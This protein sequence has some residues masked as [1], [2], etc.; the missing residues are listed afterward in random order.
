[1]AVDREQR[2]R[3]EEAR[4]RALIARTGGDPDTAEVEAL[5][6]ATVAVTADG[7]GWATLTGDDGR[8]LG[9]VLLWA[10]RRDV[11][12]LTV[13]VADGGAG[14]VARRAQGLAPVPSV[15]ALGGSRVRPAEPDPVPSWPPPDDEMR[16][17]A[18]VL[19]GAGLDVYAE[20]GTFVGEIDGLEIAR[21]VSGEDGPRLE[22]GIG[23]YDREVATLLHGD[24][25]RLDEIA[26]VAELVRAH[27]RAGA[28]HRPVG[29]LARERWLRAALVRDPS[30]LGL[31]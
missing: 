24:K 4:L 10:S 19:A 15:Y 31:G 18:D 6:P 26:R 11:G 17:L 28:D 5:D 29:V 1:M 30:P 14:I 27:R 13:F 8:G 9:A 25:P 16:A 12:P 2:A 20:Q 21:V 3:L 22:I 7:R 23:R